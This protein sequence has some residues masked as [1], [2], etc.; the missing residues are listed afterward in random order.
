M[1]SFSKSSSTTSNTIIPS[2]KTA[3]K[4][5]PPSTV[6]LEGYLMKQK[7]GKCRAWLK[8]YFVLYGEELRYYKNKDD[9]NALAVI[10]L[11]HYSLVPDA[12][13]VTSLNQKQSKLNTFCL[14]S[15]DEAKFD[16]PDYYLQAPSAQ[17]RAV[18]VDSLQDHVSQSTTVL[19]KWLDR[20]QLPPQ[21]MQALSIHQPAK[22]CSETTAS[23]SSSSTTY[24]IKELP[25]LPTSPVSP[26]TSS[27]SFIRLPSSSQRQQA[28]RYFKSAESLNTFTTRSSSNVSSSAAG[29]RRPSDFMPSRSSDLSSKLLSSKMFSWTRSKSNNSSVSSIPESIHTTDADDA[30]GRALLTPKIALESPIIH[31]SEYNHDDDPSE[32]IRDPTASYFYAKTKPFPEPTAAQQQQQSHHHH[33][34]I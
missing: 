2:V 27:S 11:D 26:T 15:D 8:R 12:Q 14:V 6:R 30:G 3:N 10:S 16:W 5:A 32:R 17:D 20:L 9:S 23:S 34:L 4:S 31:P 18:W 25:S 7:H 24:Y 13:P 29:K 22:T 33:Q 1:P 21:D 19:E 28:L